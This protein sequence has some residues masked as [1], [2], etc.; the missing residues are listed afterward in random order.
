[1]AGPKLAK[2]DTVKTI[3]DGGKRVWLYPQVVIGRLVKARSVVA[4]ILFAVLLIAPWIDVG[5][6][7]A[8][9]FDIPARKAYFWGLTFFATDAFWL[10]FAFGIGIFS[11]FFFTSVMGRLWCGWACPQTVLMESFVR[12]IERLIEGPPSKRKKLDAGPWTREK[13][14]KKG[15]K[16]GAY[17]VLAGAFATTL[18]AYF[19]GRDG[20]LAAQFDPG[21][22]PMGTAFFVVITAVVFFDIAWFREQVCVVVC[23]YGRFQSILMDADTITI[24]YDYKRGEPRGKVKDPNAG[25]CIDCKKCVAVC[26]TGIDIRHGV[27]MECI[28]CAACID[29]CD[30]IMDK[31]GRPRGLIKYASENAL[32]GNP[33]RKLRPRPVLYGLALLGLIIGLVVAVT[34]REPV[35]VRLTRMPGAVYTELPDGRRQNLMNLR[36]NNRGGDPLTVQVSVKDG[37]VEVQTPVP[38]MTVPADSIRTFPAIVVGRTDNTPY[39]L[40]VEDSTGFKADV[41]GVFMARKEVKNAP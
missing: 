4:W 39:V 2:D 29:A 32:A 9:R 27:Q 8:M 15:L 10:L 35:E 5:G 20:V 40:T 34:L 22:H 28:N 25:D 16:H 33:P 31:I 30:S 26:P 12:P 13:I 18:V 11:I 21:S 37:A 36:V 38:T 41:S 19:L 17:L 24:G 1:M 6:H 3:G 7:P 23:P 14:V